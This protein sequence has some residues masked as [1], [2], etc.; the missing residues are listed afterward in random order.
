MDTTVI[1]Q[2]I[3][4]PIDSKGNPNY[5]FMKSCMRKLEQKHLTKI[6]KYYKNKLLD[7]NGGGGRIF[8]LSLEFA[9]LLWIN[10]EAAW[11]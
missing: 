8:V 5:A 2:I 9:R 11:L 7:S 6:I 3:E 10:L 4:L 1:K